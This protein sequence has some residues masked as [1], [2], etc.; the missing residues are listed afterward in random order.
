M[1]I[2]NLE[3]FRAK[4]RNGGVC[5]GLVITLADPSVSEL[6]GDAGFDFT[7]IDAEHAP[8][9]LQTIMTHVMAQRGTGCAPF[10]RAAWNEWG[11]IKPILDLAPAGIIIPMVND[12]EA[13]ELA[14]ANCKYPPAGNRGFGVRRGAGYGAVPTPEYLRRSDSDPMVIIQIEH[15]NAVKH[16]DEILKVPGIDSVCIGPCDLSGSM[17]RLGDVNHPEVLR[18]IDEVSAKVKRA[19]LLLGTASGAPFEMWKARG[20]DWIAPIGDTEC[21]FRHAR[22]I[23]ENY[24]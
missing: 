23:L 15:I 1:D 12:R 22:T 18:V 16:L 5:V 10:V 9:T 24:R 17:G 4:I 20:I 11:I 2:N 14:V 13:A 7:W 21:L 3:K 6:A 8:H 19:G